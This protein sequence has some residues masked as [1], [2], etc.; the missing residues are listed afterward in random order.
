MI[1][2]R[3]NMVF[4]GT[5]VSHGRALAVVAATG[6]RT[7]IGRIAAS[8]NSA[9]KEKTPLQKSVDKLGHSLIWVV[10]SACVLLAGA[11]LLHGMALVDV[12]LLAVAAAVSGIP[13]GLPAAVTVV[14]AICVNRMAKRNV[15]I[16]KLTA[17]ETLG[18]ATVICSDKTGTLTLNQMTVR[19]IWSCGNLY[20]VG[21][22]GYEPLGDFRRND[23]V[24]QPAALPELS[25]LLR[26]AALCN[27]ALLSKD[28]SA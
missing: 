9:T 27:D 6:M 11:A 14:L 20:T 10:L 12:M 23:T 18:T 7:E 26:M 21:G 3:K 22:G 8:I 24:V 28:G 13:E 19:E 17:V 5:T 4:M 16:R 25:R 15:I 1:H 2:D